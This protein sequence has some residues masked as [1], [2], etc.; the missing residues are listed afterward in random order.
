MRNKLLF[1]LVGAGLVAGVASAF[2]YGRQPQAEPPVFTPA[3]NPFPQGVFANGIIESYQE[4]GQNTNMYPEVTGVV[5]AIAVHEGEHV[6]QG[7]IVLMLDDSEQ[8]ATVAQLQAQAKAARTALDQLRA[9]PRPETLAVSAAQVEQ[10]DAALGRAKATRDKQL[11]SYQL[12]PRSVSKQTLDDANAVVAEANASLDVARR[13]YELTKAGA[14]S[15]DIRNQQQQAIALEKAAASAEALL[16]KYTLRAPRD[17]IVLAMNAAV[18]SYVSPQGVYNPYTQQNDPIA[19]MGDA[20]ILAVRCYVDEIL[21]PRLGDPSK[22]TATM[23][24]RG[25][26]VEIPL[27]FVRV[28]PYVTP[29]IELSNQRTEKVDLRVLPVIFRFTP[30][31]DVRVYPG[32]LVDVYMAP[33]MSRSARRSPP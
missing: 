27:Q 17:G 28:Q 21:V 5:T 12:D 8:R 23:Q 4:H 24:V 6:K 13:Q 30:P 25:T 31:A 3:T 16:R 2:V 11:H 7:D 1:T 14:W 29:K 33:Q 10:A 26:D 22:L 32:Q 19:T 20:G 15:Y 9:Q 18:G